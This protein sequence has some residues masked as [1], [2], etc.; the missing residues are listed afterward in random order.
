M[1]SDM[2]LIDAGSEHGLELAYEP[3]TV[4]DHGSLTE[5]TLG[6]SGSASDFITGQPASG[7]NFGFLSGP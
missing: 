1:I 5:L 6:K 2:T 7:N 4:T 3:P